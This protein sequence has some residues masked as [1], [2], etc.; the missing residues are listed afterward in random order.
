MLSQRHLQLSN[1]QAVWQIKFRSSVPTV[2]KG[3]FDSLN[4]APTKPTDLLCGGIQSD[5][6]KHFCAFLSSR[7]PAMA[8][9]LRGSEFSSAPTWQPQEKCWLH[10][11]HL[12]PCKA[13]ESIFLLA[14]LLLQV[15]RCENWESS[16]TPEVQIAFAVLSVKTHL[17][18]WLLSKTDGE[19]M[20][21]KKES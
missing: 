19:S 13:T 20:G 15:M 3:Q 14:E 18:K 1:R 10:S 12:H 16:L 2:S 6:I 4:D 21:K 8:T 7:S 11:A 9:V 17:L 5:F